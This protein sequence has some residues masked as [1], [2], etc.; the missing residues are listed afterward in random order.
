MHNLEVAG[1][2]PAPATNTE[3]ALLMGAFSVFGLCAGNEQVALLVC[4]I[5]NRSDV[6]QACATARRAPD[7]SALVRQ[8]IAVPLGESRNFRAAA[9][10]YS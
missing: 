2:I 7:L 5:A 4:G 8:Q 10:K 1:A 6:A 9:R 3:K